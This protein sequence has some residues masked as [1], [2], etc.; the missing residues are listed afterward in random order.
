LIGS[1]SETLSPQVRASNGLGSYGIIYIEIYKKSRPSIQ[2]R[3]YG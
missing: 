2:L 1:Y 3:F